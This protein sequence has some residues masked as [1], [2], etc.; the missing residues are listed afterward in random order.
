M[1]K[2]YMA[3]AIIDKERMAHAMTVA[4]AHGHKITWKWPVV[5]QSGPEAAI[6]DI[7][8]VAEAD[9]LIAV[10]DQDDYAYWG[11]RHEIGA[12]MLRRQQTDGRYQIWIVCNGGD[13]T[14]KPRDA[15]PKCMRTCFE[16]TADRYFGSLPDA[17]AA[18]E[19]TTPTSS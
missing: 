18:L 15:V 1:K 8:G 19:E 2:I 5:K 4:E 10:M 11:T 12:A 3:G 9:L 6:R 13:P 17:L 16:L 7:R 14:A